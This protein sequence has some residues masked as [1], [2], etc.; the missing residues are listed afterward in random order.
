MI[1]LLKHKCDHEPA[2]MSRNVN[3][4]ACI[5][6]RHAAH[7]TFCLPCLLNWRQVCHRGMTLTEQI[8]QSS[9]VDVHTDLSRNSLT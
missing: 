1:V 8:D 6:R 4:A 9:Y 5:V 7:L 3:V 2:L